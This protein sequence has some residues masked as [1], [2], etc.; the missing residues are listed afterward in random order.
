MRRNFHLKG[1]SCTVGYL[2]PVK[3]ALPSKKKGENHQQTTTVAMKLLL[4]SS[5]S[6]R[7]LVFTLLQHKRHF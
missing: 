3:E 6:F 5:Y 2:V 7:E 4:I 1:S